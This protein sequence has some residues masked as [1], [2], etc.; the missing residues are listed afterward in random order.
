MPEFPQGKPS[1]AL[2]GRSPSAAPERNHGS[3]GRGHLSPGD[4]AGGAAAVTLGGRRRRRQ[5]QKA[6]R[7][8]E[9]A[10]APSMLAFLARHG[11]GGEC[12]HSGPAEQVAAAAAALRDQGWA[13][14]W[15][16]VESMDA[17]KW[18][19]HRPPPPAGQ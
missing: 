11:S 16:P 10:A 9:L 14:V 13:I 6:E 19:W 17:P 2:L 4:D 1:S 18:D 3:I 15:L 8:L 5:I 12:R 7:A